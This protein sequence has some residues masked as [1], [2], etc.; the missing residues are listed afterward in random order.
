MTS[1]TP[2]TCLSDL[3]EVA[4]DRA[5]ARVEGSTFWSMLVSVRKKFPEE[6][7]SFYEVR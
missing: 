5:N 3:L 4:L 2:D 7:I 6:R 1:R